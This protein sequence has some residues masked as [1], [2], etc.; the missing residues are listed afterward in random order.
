MKLVAGNSAPDFS[1]PTD[2]GEN[3]SLSDFFYKKNIVLYFYPKDDTPGCTLEAKGFRD[4]IND[5]SSLD[6]VII[7]V[8]R[9]SVKCH[10]NFKAKYSLPFYL[11]SDENA[12][13]SEKY[14]VWVEKSMFGKKYTGIER[15]TFLIDKK[16]K[17]VRIWKDV[18]VSGHINEVLEEVKKIQI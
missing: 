11:V 5:F 4:K 8:S 13:M 18:K 2:S 9:D 16:D 1:L 15:T 10:A 14:G 7:G 3:L 17:I 6:T 12:E